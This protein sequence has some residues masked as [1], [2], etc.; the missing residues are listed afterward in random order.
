MTRSR[1]EPITRCKGPPTCIY[2]L[3]SFLVLLTRPHEAALSRTISS[4]PLALPR[5]LS[6]T[7]QPYLSHISC[8]II[9]FYHHDIINQQSGT[10][11][12]GS[13]GLGARGLAH[14][15]PTRAS[16]QRIPAAPGEEEESRSRSESAMQTCEPG[17]G[18]RHIDMNPPPLPPPPLTTIYMITD[19]LYPMHP[20]AHEEALP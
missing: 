15:R 11:C 14:A 16:A 20:R 10:R 7:I 18:S 4:G 2:A 1:P 5:S 9:S 17:C 13:C 3:T 19:R 12:S 6:T 8:V